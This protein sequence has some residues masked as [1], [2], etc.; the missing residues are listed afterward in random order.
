MPPPEVKVCELIDVIVLLEIAAGWFCASAGI[1]NGASRQS[2][3]NRG[4]PLCV[5]KLYP[6]RAVVA[7][8][9][10]VAVRKI[11][12]LRGLSGGMER[13]PPSPPLP[14]FVF[15]SIGRSRISDSRGLL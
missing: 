10:F 2:K 13:I 11:S 5:R 8:L 3:R 1:A 4:R 12:N 15:T 14:L 7:F 6:T 9:A